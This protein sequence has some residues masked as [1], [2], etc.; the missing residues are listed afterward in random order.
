MDEQIDAHIKIILEKYNLNSAYNKYF[1]MALINSV[2]NDGFHWLLLY[3]SNMLKSKPDLILYCTLILFKVLIITVPVEN[4]S[5]YITNNFL[6][7]FKIANSDYYN[8]RI[9]QLEK[10]RILDLDLV[11]YYTILDH[12]NDNLEE[13]I[14]NI[15]RKYDIPLRFITLILISYNK[16]FPL[17]IILFMIYYVYVKTLYEKKIEKE[18]YL[19]NEYFKYDNNIR[20]YLVNSKSFLI[21]DEFNYKYYLDN[22][23]K[24]ESTNYSILNINTNIENKINMAMFLYIFIIISYRFDQITPF[25]FITYF[26]IIYDIQYVSNKLNQY[27]RSKINNV[28][29]CERLQ[30]LNKFIPQNKEKFTNRIKINYIEIDNIN[31]TNPKLILKDKL[32][33]HKNDHFLIN[34][35]SGSGKTSFIYILKGIVKCDNI[36]IKP[37]ISEIKKNA[38]I[39]LP[40]YKDLFDGNLYDIISNYNDNYNINLIKESI[41]LSKFPSD[42]N[43]KYINVEK[44]SMGEK[45]RLVIARTIYTIKDKNYNILL[46]DEIDQNLNEDF[47][48]EI[49]LTIKNI[50]KNNIIFYITHIDKVK[51]IFDKEL[52]VENGVVTRIK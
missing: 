22:I 5:K 52:Y 10:N 9:I 26:L 2:L 34:G 7:E 43:N 29:M 24:L 45:I 51:N 46:F 31:I 30:Y 16:N 35:K 18:L 13:Y 38:Y 23:E 33:I 20:N 28:K 14:V 36:K 21:N 39:F 42:G 25:D 3:F 17:I 47:A 6:K 41:K 49:C 27:Y 50:F 12:I 4:Y 8:K 19:T 1:Y 44:L 40:N 48:Y 37:N 15:K 11:N 32:V